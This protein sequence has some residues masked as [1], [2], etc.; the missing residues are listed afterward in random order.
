MEMVS[1][2]K[3]MENFHEMTDVIVRDFINTLHKC[4]MFLDLTVEVKDLEDDV[5]VCG[6]CFPKGDKIVI[7]KDG[8]TEV[9]N[10][11]GNSGMACIEA[12]W[13]GICKL[14][15]INQM[16]VPRV[17]YDRLLEIATKLWDGLVQDDEDEAY[18]Y[19][20]NEL[21]MTDD[22]MELLGIDAKKKD[23][24]KVITYFDNKGFNIDE[25]QAEEFID[26]FEVGALNNIELI[27][28]DEDLIE[29]YLDLEY[30]KMSVL[31]GNITV[32]SLAED[33]CSENSREYYRLAEDIV[34]VWY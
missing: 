9:V 28:N 31:W 30:E 18:E 33:I 1:R 29:R 6:K 12:I 2:F 22:E 24:Q 27:L 34:I 26:E 25:Y 10:I 32:S 3:T 14:Y 19:I 11:T 20:K 15:G 13:K 8:N 7:L 17:A 21:D 23:I 5:Y 16:P 4:R